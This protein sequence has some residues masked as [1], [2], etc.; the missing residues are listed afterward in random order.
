MKI[1]FWGCRGSLPSSILGN[2]IEQKIRFSLER[3]IEHGLN[4][5]SNLDDFIDQLPFSVRSTFGS[6]T[7][8]VEILGGKEILICDAGSGIRDFG[9][10]LVSNPSNQPRIINLFLSHLHWDHLQGFPFF[11]PAYIQGTVIKIWGGHP[12]F[13]DALMQQQ[14]PPFFPVL[15]E[16]MGANISFHTFESDD[17]INI[18]GID[19][20]II[21]QPHPGKSFGFCFR[22]NDKKIVYST[23]IEHTEAVDD[24]ANKFI[25]FYQDADVLIIDGQFN[26]ADHL[27]T[28]QNWGHS[29]NLIAIELAVLS[30]VKTLC[31][32]HADHHLSD[33]Q[34]EKFLLDSKRYL[35]IYAPESTLNL[36]LAYDGMLIDINR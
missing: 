12:G 31:L 33:V 11:I 16:D 22:K 36:E 10:Y 13:K 28:K 29:S 21:E 34:L 17:S 9:K 30:Q 14:N 4:S 23:D 27:Y 2:Q 3:A 32:F 19:I 6:N 15:L 25:Q 5:G 20:S 1:K 24:K 7:P 18:G 8:C 35:E 26:L